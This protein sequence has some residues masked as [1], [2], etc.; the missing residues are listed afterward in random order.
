MTQITNKSCMYNPSALI[1]GTIPNRT[2]DLVL[3][4]WIIYTYVC[5]V[6]WMLFVVVTLSVGHTLL[7]FELVEAIFAVIVSFIGLIIQHISMWAV[8]NVYQRIQDLE[9]INV[10]HIGNPTTN[11]DILNANFADA[12]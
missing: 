4:C 10:D 8:I 12:I 6:L 1:C 5:W 11:I 2:T 7:P 9:N 3:S